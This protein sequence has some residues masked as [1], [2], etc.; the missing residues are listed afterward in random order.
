MSGQPISSE[1][2]AQV[3]AL[4]QCCVHVSQATDREA[5]EAKALELA[6]LEKAV[7]QKQQVVDNVEAKVDVYSQ[8]E[9]L[10]KKL[11]FFKLLAE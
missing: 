7:M 1:T 4:W 3:P 5:L 11:L 2:A 10:C 9:Q 6:A 8:A